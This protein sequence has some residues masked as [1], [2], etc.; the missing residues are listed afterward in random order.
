MYVYMH[1]SSCI[2]PCIIRFDG[3]SVLTRFAK[4]HK[5]FKEKFVYYK[6][7][8]TLGVLTVVGGPGMRIH[9]MTAA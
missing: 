1:R 3:G 6:K 4:Q 9:L 8:Q 7:V 2:K 5:I